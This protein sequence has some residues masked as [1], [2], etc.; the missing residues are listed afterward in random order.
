MI[1]STLLGVNMIMIN[2][3][4]LWVLELA[5]VCHMTES[6]ELAWVKWT[7]AYWAM[8][9]GVTNEHD[10]HHAWNGMAHIH[11]NCL[12]KVIYECKLLTNV[13]TNFLRCS[14]DTTQPVLCGSYIWVF[15]NYHLLYIKWHE[16][17]TRKKYSRKS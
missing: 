10:M 4:M 1:K 8:I 13:Y 6:L 2:P 5:F 16:G 15:V 12:L 11:A 14:L 7:R 9:N 17:L 3:Q